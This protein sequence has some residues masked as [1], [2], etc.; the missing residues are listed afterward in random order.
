MKVSHHM[1]I[2]FWLNISKKADNNTAPIY[3][4]ITINGKR[5]QFSKG[6]FIT[7]DQWDDKAKSIKGNSEQVRTW[8]QDLT[9]TKSDLTSICNRLQYLHDV[10]TPE[11]IIKEFKGDMPQRKT[12]MD[13]FEEHNRLLLERTEAREKSLSTKTWQRFEITKGKVKKFL[14]HRYNLSDKPISE[15]PKSFGEEFR[16]FLNT[17]E[18]IGMNTAMKYCK[19]TKQMLNYALLKE[20]V[21]TNPMAMFKC[22]Y[23]NPKRERLTWSELLSLYNTAMPVDRLEE[24][25]DVYVFSCFT[26]YAYIDVYKLEP[27]NVMHWIDNSKW[28]I[29]DRHKGDHNKS[30]VPLMEIPLVIIEKYKQHP[31]CLNYNKLLPVNS[32]QRYNAYLKE[33]AAI[34][35][36][37]KEL[38]THTAR[39]TFATTVLLD[40]DCPIESVSEMLGHNSIRTTQI[41][42]KTTDI[43]ISHNMKDVRLRITEKIQSAANNNEIK[44]GT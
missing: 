3:C 15:I 26:G 19:N 7:K 6:I 8:N 13:V 33:I 34:A 2:L 29:K 36:V 5:G 24:V 25:K 14:Q 11:M 35:G 1:A 44:T 42:A 27:E 41:Y 28:L 12:L 17:V 22:V 23:K 38:T 21:T 20:Y 39:H 4:R 16:H 37:K 18:K 43:K 32:N 40:N 10:I 9:K 30:N 31:Y